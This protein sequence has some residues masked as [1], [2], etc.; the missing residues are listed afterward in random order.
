MRSKF[1]PTTTGKYAAGGAVL[2]GAAGLGISQLATRKLRAEKKILEKKK[3]K[4]PADISRIKSLTKKIRIARIGST[5][6]GA[7]AGLVAGHEAGAN[8]EYKDATNKA[9][10]NARKENSKREVT[11][12][13][14]NS[15]YRVT[16]GR[17]DTAH[18]RSKNWLSKNKRDAFVQGSV[19]SVFRRKDADNGKLAIVDTVKLKEFKGPDNKFTKSTRVP[20]HSVIRGNVHTDSRGKLSNRE[21]WTNGKKD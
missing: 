2:G 1:K 20:H 10:N 9:I 6:V 17:T 14:P 15:D 21:D 4:S 8:K 13:A 16:G 3:D 5:V 11:T 19:R 18:V 12:Y 7:G